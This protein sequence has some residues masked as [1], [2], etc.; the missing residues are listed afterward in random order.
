ML[1]SSGKCTVREVKKRSK[2]SRTLPGRLKLLTGGGSCAN[3]SKKE[4]DEDRSIT[5]P[6]NH[7]HQY[8]CSNNNNTTGGRRQSKSSKKLSV[9]KTPEGQHWCFDVDAYGIY[10]D[11]N[12]EFMRRS[13]S[14]DELRPGSVSGG[15]FM[16]MGG[17]N[18]SRDSHNDSTSTSSSSTRSKSLTR[19]SGGKKC[20]NASLSNST[21]SMSRTRS[22]S[23]LQ[24]MNNSLSQCFGFGGSSGHLKKGSRNYDSS[25]H[26][27]IGDDDSEEYGSDAYVRY[28]QASASA[29][30]SSS[31]VE[32]RSGR[33]RDNEQLHGSSHHET[34]NKTMSGSSAFGDLG[35][36]D[37]RYYPS[38][39]FSFHFKYILQ[40]K[41]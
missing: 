36:D 31:T 25:Q 26:S 4:E 39:C 28:V 27:D 38:G 19:Q 13:A 3:V 6:P 40:R 22:R 21:R 10:M 30:S 1:S 8:Q 37:E 17:S 7:H 33:R 16:G 14:K 29:S 23:R 11:L 20:L 15:E 18:G 34:L 41:R 12:G 2:K 32:R 35:D 24:T 9:F 5:P